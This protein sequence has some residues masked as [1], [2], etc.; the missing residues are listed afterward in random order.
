METFKCFILKIF[1]LQAY[2]DSMLDAISILKF[3]ERRCRI[4]FYCRESIQRIFSYSK[5][6]EE[7][8]IIRIKA[9]LEEVMIMHSVLS[10]ECPKDRVLNSEWRKGQYNVTH[11][12]VGFLPPRL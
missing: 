9:V 1:G 11:L 5:Y 7:E 3:E 2:I 6:P 12:R 4:D 8:K 10:K